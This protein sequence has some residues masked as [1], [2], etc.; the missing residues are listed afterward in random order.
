MSKSWFV[1]FGAPGVSGVALAVVLGGF[2]SRSWTLRLLTLGVAALVLVVTMCALAGCAGGV[3]GEATA[4]ATAESWGAALEAGNTTQF[5]SLFSAD[6]AFDGVDRDPAGGATGDGPPAPG[7]MGRE[8]T[9]TV[10]IVDVVENGDTAIAHVKVTYTGFLSYMAGGDSGSG[11]SGDAP[12][13][14]DGYADPGVSPPGAPDATD[15]SD[16]ATAPEFAVRE[17]SGEQIDTTPL[18][19]TAFYE[20]G[21]ARVDTTWVVVSLRQVWTTLLVGNGAQAPL[22][23][24]LLADGSVTPTVDPRAEVTVTGTVRQTTESTIA[25]RIGYM[26]SGL[27]VEGTTFAGAV[28]SPRRAGDYVLEVRA[29]NQSAED[30]AYGIA[31]RSLP[32]TVREAAG[33]GFT[34]A[35]GSGVALSS[36]EEQA[37]RGLCLAIY[38]SDWDAAAATIDP[39]Y[40]YDGGDPWSAIW[41]LP[42]GWYEES[43]LAVTVTEAT[44]TASGRAVTLHM[45]QV[46]EN[47]WGYGDVPDDTDGTTPPDAGGDTAERPTLPPHFANMERMRTQQAGARGA[48][49]WDHLTTEGDVTLE[50]GNDALITAVRPLVIATTQGEAPSLALGPLTGNGSESPSLAGG[51]DFTVAGSVE[52]TAQWLALSNSESSVSFS[53]T[54]GAYEGTLASPFTR[55]RW[56]TWATAGAWTETGSIYLSRTLEVTVTSDAVTPTFAATADV[57]APVVASLDEWLAGLWLSSPERLATAYSEEYSYDGRTKS[58]VVASP[59][60]SVWHARVERAEVA[61]GPSAGRYAVALEF[62]GPYQWFSGPWYGDGDIVRP[63]Q[64]TDCAPNAGYDS[65]VG[66]ACTKLRMTFG[67]DAAGRIVSERIDAGLCT[68]EGITPV[69]LSDLTIDGAAPGRLAAGAE[70]LLAATADGSVASVEGRIGPN[71]QWASEPRVTV[72]APTA[73]GTYLAEMVLSP[74]YAVDGPPTDALCMPAPTSVAIVGAEVTVE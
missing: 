74:G 23:D 25:C 62:T 33:A 5:E 35:V 10:E 7:C 21:L 1:R 22:I 16:G 57:P 28:R 68:Y 55:G 44:E 52:G 18:I 64:E 38:N 2:T 60:L 49:G 4:R 56:L 17:V 67:F 15:P 63:A 40:A 59:R 24:D 61:A 73:P 69:S 70:V 30:S 51:V 41:R 66:A 72:T 27:P 54:T 20:L 9:T 36:A 11:W 3:T 71:R 29:I 48:Y 53:E 8:G 58:D 65:Y 6:Y 14:G 43:D 45:R 47:F 42:V 39:S 50:L 13:A 31:T 32:V 46:A 12:G 37:L 34:F 26:E 19:F